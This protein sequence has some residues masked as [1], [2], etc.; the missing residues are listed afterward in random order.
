MP[1]TTQLGIIKPS[2]NDKVKLEDFN[3]NWDKID[4][5]VGSNNLILGNHDW[6]NLIYEKSAQSQV[7]HNVALSG[8]VVKGKSTIKIR[9]RMPVDEHSLYY[10]KVKVKTDTP[11]NGSFYLGAIPLDH[12]FEEIKLKNNNGEDTAAAGYR[13]FLGKQTLATT[14]NT[15]EG[16]ISGY[17]PISENANANDTNK[18]P[19]GTSYF[20]IILLCNQESNV[21]NAKTIMQSIEVYKVVE[22]FTKDSIALGNQDWSHLV[23]SDRNKLTYMNTVEQNNVQGM[24]VTG[25]NAH[26]KVRVRIPVDKDAMYYAK[27]KVKSNNHNGS[28]YAGAIALNEQYKLMNEGTKYFICANESLSGN[29]SIFQGYI[30]GYVQNGDDALEK[31]YK[32][33]NQTNYFDLYLF[34]NVNST[35]EDPKTIIESLEVYKVTQPVEKDSLTLGNQDWSQYVYTDRSNLSYN[36]TAEGMIVQGNTWMK[37]ALRMPVDRDSEYYARVKVK[38]ISKVNGSNPKFYLGAI[39]LNH[40]YQEIRIPDANN[41]N[42]SAQRAYRY[43]VTGGKQLDPSKNAEIYEGVISG[44]SPIKISSNSNENINNHFKFPYGTSYFDLVL[45]CNGQGAALDKTLIQSIEVFKAPKRLVVTG[46][47]EVKSDSINLDNLQHIVAKKANDN[48]LHHISWGD[49]KKGIVKSIQS[50]TITVNNNNEQ[51]GYYD[52]DITQVENTANCI[53]TVDIKKVLTQKSSESVGFWLSKAQVYFV[54]FKSNNKMTFRVERPES[55]QVQISYK[56]IELA[57][58]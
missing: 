14:M 1:T 10:A 21:A 15:Y 38:Q 52:L 46:K 13:Y 39:P 29:S 17:F 19:E 7:E 27:V 43:F 8:M 20:D 41:Q 36:K 47:A 31:R 55:Y 58:S 54:G 5:L 23:Y 11:N 51:I 25:K 57:Y 35:N 28:F 12:N 42:P 50:G 34:C 9:M 45:I 3:K 33:P 6:S 18:F 4:S 53:V 22:P 48:T 49:L 37:V 16:S 26:I 44:Y 32:F 2:P 30:S 24:V 40:K 56:V